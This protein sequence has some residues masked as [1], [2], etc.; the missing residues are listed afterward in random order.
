MEFQDSMYNRDVSSF[1]FEHN[2]ITN[3]DWFFFIVRQKQQIST[4]ECWFH[5]STVWQE[6]PLAGF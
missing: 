2:N 4:M 3:S 1:H 6:K 5:T